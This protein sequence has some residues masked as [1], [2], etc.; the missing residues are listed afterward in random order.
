MVERYVGGGIGDFSVEDVF[1]VLLGV[2]SGT[3]SNA[4]G[5]VAVLAKLLLNKHLL[6][7]VVDNTL[8]IADEK[9]CHSG[10]VEEEERVTGEE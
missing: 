10:E 5:R 9:G 6:M 2:D 4:P 8:S 3:L 1:S 7:V